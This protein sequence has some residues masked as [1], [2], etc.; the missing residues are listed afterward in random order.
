IRVRSTTVSMMRLLRSRTR[1]VVFC[2]PLSSA[3]TRAV[4]VTAIVMPDAA[5]K[6]KRMERWRGSHPSLVLQCKM[7][8]ASVM[9]VQYYRWVF[10]FRYDDEQVVVR[11]ALDRGL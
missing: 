8:P 10:S 9:K 11:A 1:A 2:R 3:R 7:L 4:A 6:A 5:A